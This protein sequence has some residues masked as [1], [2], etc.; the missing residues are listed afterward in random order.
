MCAQSPATGAG[1][2]VRQA[3]DQKRRLE[4]DNAGFSE[5]VLRFQDMAFGYACAITGDPNRSQDIVQESFLRAWEHLH[6]LHNPDAFPGWFRQIV[7]RA[8]LDL[9]A[10]EPHTSLSV[11]AEAGLASTIGGPMEDLLARESAGEIQEAIS[12]LPETLRTS[13]VLYYVDGYTHQEIADFLEI[14]L[15]AVK[16]RMQ[17]GRD[18]MRRNLEERIRR[19][20]GEMKPSNDGRL[21]ATVNIYTN[22]SIAGQLG[23]ITLLEAMLVDGIDVNE[24]DAMGRSLLHWAVES[25]HVDAVEL[26][27]RNGADPDVRDHEGRTPRDIASEHDDKPILGM[28]DER[29]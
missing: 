4:L 9:I 2:L 10:R 13:V 12:G 26:L 19:T 5:L 18:Q 23:Q 27:L 6:Q 21:L 1:E 25:A 7:R 14:S 11:D 29:R 24:L 15:S 20:V 28:L 16:K 3:L 17:R 22:F 8:A